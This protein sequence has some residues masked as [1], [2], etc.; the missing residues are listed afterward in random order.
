MRPRK[1]LL[2][3]AALTAALVAAGIQQAYAGD[4]LLSQGRPSLASSSENVDT[5]AAAAFDG[6]AGTRWGSQWTDPQWLRVD[7]GATAT[8]S[9]VILS[10]E[11]A[12]AKAYQIQTSPDGNAWTDVYRTTTS[13]GGE[14]TLTV[15]GSG[16]YVRML[17][18]QR[19]TSYGYS[20]F[21]F[22][23]YGTSSVTPPPTDGPGYIMADP[24]VTGVVPSTAYPP[25]TNPP[26]THHEFQANC[27]VSR[28]NLQDDPIVFPN[29]PGASH[30]HTF[31]GN[32][33]TN[34]TTSL[35]SLQAGTTTCTVPG[36]RS[37]YWQPTLYNGDVAV[38]PDGPQVIY[39]KSGVRDWRSVRPSPPG[40]RY[41]V[42]S[43]SASL[44]DFQNS[45]G[46]VE[47]WECGDSS[48]NWDFPASCV[49]GSLLNVRFQAPS[50]W[51][52]IHLDSPDHKSHM[53]YPVL[54]VCP[55]DHPVAVP[56][57]E[58]KMSWP[59]SGNMTN[60]HFSSGRGYSYHYDFF[61]A[62][63]P[64][65]LNALVVH[66]INGGLQCNP[67]GFDQYKPDR[68]AALTED[69]QLP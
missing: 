34:A 14:Q 13:A 35:A 36:D 28:T 18:T 68:G 46:A 16:R 2:G 11:V 3:V 44:S 65:I 17:G 7:L 20:L 60:L 55:D 24:P 38:Q 52:G 61:N 19:G 47:G 51:D 10:W 9:K 29:L 64:A 49:Q 53:A 41:L 8:I 23:V 45:P 59:V 22:K 25:D 63:D 62:W 67:R 43:P 30:F 33:T 54:G 69:Y 50:C 40:L 66:C 21:E 15:T 6:S 42:G 39:Y 4:S 31:L 1:R 27:S 57:L 58:F 5:P 32:R 26:T 37:G 48:R 12:Y 56:M